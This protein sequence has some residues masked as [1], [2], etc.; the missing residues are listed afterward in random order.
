MGSVALQRGGVLKFS[1]TDKQMTDTATVV[2]D[3]A[4]GAKSALE[5]Q[6]E[7]TIALADIEN[8]VAQRLKQMSR[9]VKMAGFRPGK[10]PLKLVEQQ[11]GAQAR[12]EAIG[13]AVQKSFSDAVRQQ[14]LRV[15]GYPRIAPNTTVG[16][17][18]LGFSAVFEVYPEIVL[19]DVSGQSIEKPGLTVT[20][21]EMDKTLDV[22]RKQRVTY[23]ETDRASQTNDRLVID[24]TG[25]KDGVEF[26]GGQAS[27]YSVVVGGGSML[28]DFE[29]Q[30]EGVKAGEK[31]TFDVSFPAE[32]QSKELA[33]AVAQFDITVKKVEAAV[34]PEIDA[35]FAKQLGVADGDV[36]TMLAEVRANLEREVT[37]R[38]Q[39]RV[40][41]Q[42]MGALLAV[43]PIEVPKALVEAESHQMVEAAK[44]DMESRGMDVKN[45]PVQPAWFADKA[46]RRVKLG[47]IV[48]ELVKSKNLQ[49][50]PEQVRK[51]VDDF[52]ETF[53][54]PREVVRWYYSDPQR[55]A[56]AEA[57][58]LENNVVDWVLSQAKVTEKTIA[59]SEL[60]GDQA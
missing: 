10:V 29:A 42:V 3:S 35:D 49:V 55:L 24:F 7:V 4:V 2:A 36:S 30:L 38:L 14:K 54:D 11:H 59:F 18:K 15:A 17:G 46:L 60:M 58:A 6:I 48:G 19:A 53:E 16:E 22:L 25:R 26:S 12:S 47:L 9:S 52:A 37:K 28:P 5:R 32:Y 44:R 31:K 20:D 27:D 50:K 23:A 45:I 8:D 41:E 1:T 39:S 21:A 56:E 13:D 43:N 57:L 51:I 40:K 33:G 34:L